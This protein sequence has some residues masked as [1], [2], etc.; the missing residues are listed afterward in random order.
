MVTTSMPVSNHRGHYHM[1]QESLSCWWENGDSLRSGDLRS[2]CWPKLTWNKSLSISATA[3]FSRAEDE[4][5]FCFPTSLP[6]SP[7]GRLRTY[8]GDHGVGGTAKVPCFFLG[9]PAC[10]PLPIVTEV[11]GGGTPRRQLLTSHWCN[12]PGNTPVDFWFVL[13]SNRLETNERWLCHGHT[14]HHTWRWA[15]VGADRTE[16]LRGAQSSRK[17]LQL[18]VMSDS[19]TSALHSIFRRTHY[20]GWA[21][22]EAA[23]LPPQPG[24]VLG[25][26]GTRQTSE[27]HDKCSGTQT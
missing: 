25:I 10:T 21:S 15:L 8:T 5:C 20:R 3:V 22:P 7:P 18:T 23:P 4:K 9:D 26:W 12:S 13:Q 2:N 27:K 16:V 19:W 6:A 17:R 1:S 11:S 24:G 14:Q